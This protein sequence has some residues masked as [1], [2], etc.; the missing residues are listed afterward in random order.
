M[1][2]SATIKFK[3]EGKQKGYVINEDDGNITISLFVDLNKSNWK[4]DE[5][6][7]IEGEDITQVVSTYAHR[8]SQRR[9]DHE[10][11]QRVHFED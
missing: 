9:I 5:E 7:I 8:L 2:T 10:I 11:I 6:E 3:E 1:T 4:R